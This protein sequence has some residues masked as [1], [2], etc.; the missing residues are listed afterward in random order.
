[1]RERKAHLKVKEQRETLKQKQSEIIDYRAEIERK[2]TEHRMVIQ[3][4]RNAH[5]MELDA[6]TLQLMHCVRIFTETPENREAMIAN[7][8]DGFDGVITKSEIAAV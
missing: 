1:M 4:I 7:M 2:D 6:V 8:C 5:R 3:Q